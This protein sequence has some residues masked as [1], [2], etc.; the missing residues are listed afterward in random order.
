MILVPG[1]ENH[2]YK[3]I[4]FNYLHYFRRYPNVQIFVGHPIWLYT[5]VAS[6]NMVLDTLKKTTRHLM[7]KKKRIFEQFDV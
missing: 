4:E 3:K 1:L 5:N 2:M 6:C 7:Y